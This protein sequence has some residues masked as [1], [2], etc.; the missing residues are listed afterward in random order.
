MI[1]EKKTL[2]LLADRRL[3]SR[4]NNNKNVISD[5]NNNNNIIKNM[6]NHYSATKVDKISNIINN[7]SK[8]ISYMIIYICVVN[9]YCLN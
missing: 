2:E 6:N 3:L 9:L 1:Y 4:H 7:I 5:D 8:Y